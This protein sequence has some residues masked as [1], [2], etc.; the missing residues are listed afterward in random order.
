MSHELRTP[1][2]SLLILSNLLAENDQGNLSDKQLE[3][4][5][6]IHTA[7]TD[8]L[9]LISDIL[10]LSKIEAGRMEILPDL[11]AI[12]DVQDYVQRTF[13]PV[14]GD[15]GLRFEVIAG[16]GLP[17]TIVT[18]EQR[19]QQILR[20]LL[21]NAFKFTKLGGVTLSIA[22]HSAKRLAFTVSDSGAGIPAEKLQVIFEAFQQADGTTSRRYGGTG[23]G[24]SISRELARALGG[25][26][27]VDSEVG[28]GSSFTLLL[29]LAFSAP[30][31]AGAGD[32]TSAASGNGTAGDDPGQSTGELIV[33]A[34]Q[35][36]AGV[37]QAAPALAADVF[38]AQ[39][40]HGRLLHK[41]L[42]IAER[43]GKAARA[44]T[45]L[46]G[47]DKGVQLVQTTSR[48]QAEAALNEGAFDCVLLG[49]GLPK[50]EMF[51]IL[52]HL[53]GDRESQDV[54]VLLCP[55]R[56]LTERDRA[57]LARHASVTIKLVSALDQ[58]TAETAVV[59]H[60]APARGAAERSVQPRS[61]EDAGLAGRKVLIVDDDVRNLFAIASLLEGRG[62][63]VA[64]SETG[65]EA[66]AVLEHQRDIDLVLMDIMMP[67]MDG[68]QTMAAIRAM[69]KFSGL[70]IIA[71]TA[72]AMQGDREKSLQAGASDYITKPVEPEK[73]VAL[74]RTWL[75]G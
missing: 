36:R 44:V 26:I 27:Q 33:V 61:D 64:F 68:Y 49:P 1:L 57:R 41:R 20:N 29:P 14:A 55:G 24:L 45:G 65:Q 60:R 48:E 34:E 73:L 21:S 32:D 12:A 28:V 40:R 7:G 50:T 6:T 37:S 54:P 75:A 53:G 30:A 35:W 52:G 66:L 8:L 23:L 47:R 69:P 51:G 16:G 67:G 19:L 18:D 13:G 74:I 63:E 11:V 56:A 3:F 39:H 15:K 42:L 58:L 2:N 4:V 5:R 72:K 62:M 38:E 17:A 43:G 31:A 25:E 70:P 22:K 71:V 10:D 46:V 59:L 9:E